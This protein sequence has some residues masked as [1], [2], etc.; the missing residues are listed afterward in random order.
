MTSCLFLRFAALDLS[1][2]A[3]EKCLHDFWI[4]Y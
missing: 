3:D 4:V 2:V 1:P